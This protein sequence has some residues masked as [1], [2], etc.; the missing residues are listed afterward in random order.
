MVNI[1]NNIQGK[2]ATEKSKD[3]AKSDAKGKLR[4]KAPKILKA[5]EGGGKARKKKWSKSKSKDKSNNAI[6]WSKANFDKLQKDIIAKEP[7]ISP[8]V[9][10]DKLKINVSMAREAIRALVDEGKLKHNSESHSKYSCFVKTAAFVAPVAEKTDV[11]AKAPQEKKAPAK[12][13]I[14]VT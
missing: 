4:D 9:I 14:I 13:Q 12:K 10:S 5:G 11:K 8:S 7:Y 3:K 6:F 1:I 2:T